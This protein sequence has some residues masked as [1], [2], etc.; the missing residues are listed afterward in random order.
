[1]FAAKPHPLLV[2]FEGTFAVRDA[3]TE[4]PK[5]K[6]KDHWQERL[7]DEAKALGEAQYRLY[8]DARY[9]VL[10]VFQALDAAGKDGTIRHVF[11][12]VNPCACA[13]R[14]SNGRARSS[15]PT[16]S[17]GAPRGKCPSA[18]PSQSSIAATT[19]K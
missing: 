4:P 19:R 3:P 17:C 18:V 16:T 10:L 7:D 11:A 5:D 6:D 15:S 13:S 9:A 2:P 14:R 12:G 1:M 8:A